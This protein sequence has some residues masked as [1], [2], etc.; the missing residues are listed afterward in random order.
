MDE[1]QKAKE[2]AY[3]REYYLKNKERHAAIMKQRYLKNKESHAA[4]MKRWKLENKERNAANKKLWRLKNK[5]RDTANINKWKLQNKGL[6]AAS[7][8][9]YRATKFRATVYM[10]PEM[11]RKVA[12]VY[13]IAQEASVTTGYNWDVDHI[14]PLSKGGLHT[15]NNLQVVPATWNRSKNNNNC[16][17]Y[18]D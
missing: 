11:K 6:C 9:R 7:L 13:Q 3:K 14:V 12:E 17:R 18:W 5:E 10:S 15:L 1:I 2:K 4:S 8:A 16:D